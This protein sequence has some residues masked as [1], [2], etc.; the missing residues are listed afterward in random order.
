MNDCVFC[1]IIRR[2]LPASVVYED[3]ETLAFLDL[4]QPSA[5]HVLVVPKFHV[6]TIF[7]LESELAARLMQTVVLTACAVRKSLGPAGV[8]LW[9]SNGRA[10]G[11]EVPHVHVHVLAREEGDGLFPMYSQPP[12]L[13]EGEALDRL[14]ASIRAGFGEPS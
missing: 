8:N 9:Q 2:E 1:R 14:A 3:D 13:P 12:P 7:D 11:Q 10:A 5:A 6:E 4:R